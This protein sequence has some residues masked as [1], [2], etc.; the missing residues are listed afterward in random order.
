MRFPLDSEFV[1]VDTAV[2]ESGDVEAPQGPSRSRDQVCVSHE[3]ARVLSEKNRARG[4]SSA[5]VVEAEHLLLGCVYSTGQRQSI[6]VL[7]RNL[8]AT[9]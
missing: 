9:V 8:T 2:P 6:G 3:A 5:P 7:R 1:S 4:T